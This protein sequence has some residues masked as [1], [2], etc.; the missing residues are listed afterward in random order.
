MRVS[1]VARTRRTF[2]P[3][4]LSDAVLLMQ[5]A[6]L[7]DFVQQAAFPGPRAK[8]REIF[9]ALL[10]RTDVAHLDD[11]QGVLALRTSGEEHVCIQL[12]WGTFDTISEVLDQRRR[13]CF[14]EATRK[15][16]KKKEKEKKERLERKEHRDSPF[17]H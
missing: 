14:I 8:G 17:A 9:L 11:D 4:D 16:K 10:S 1:G 3:Q 13:R 12:S 2:T 6:F 15:L 5:E 7:V